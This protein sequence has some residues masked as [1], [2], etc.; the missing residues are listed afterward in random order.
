MNNEQ[1][2][3]VLKELHLIT[4]FRASLHDTEFEEIAAYPNE[5]NEFCSFTSIC[6]ET[7]SELC[8]KNRNRA[9]KKVIEAGATLVNRCRLG[10]VE[11]ISPLYNFG[12]LTGFLKIS[13]ARVDG[14]DIFPLLAMLRTGG[15]SDFAAR[16]VVSGIPTVK[17]NMI[18]PYVSMCS[19]CASYLTLSSSVSSPKAS[20]GQL[21]MK[22]IREHFTEKISVADICRA[23]GYSKST[24]LATFKKEFSTTV[25]SYLNALR[26]EKA[27]AMLEN[28]SASVNE[29]ALS[30]G[31]ADQSYFSKVFSQTYHVT[32]TEF[33][34]ARE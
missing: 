33:R 12:I 11:I 20:V 7:E 8:K 34:R 24:V 25:N 13:G 21:T 14:E 6:S 26:L 28:E 31:F 9:F 2:Q 15:K 10:L 23:V 4:G 18:K 16:E 29:I 30:C 5:K 3:D 27:R 17:E 32:P 1:I 19:I 22:F